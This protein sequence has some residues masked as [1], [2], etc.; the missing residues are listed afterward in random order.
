MKQKIFRIFFFIFIVSIYSSCSKSDDDTVIVESST[1]TININGNTG[2]VKENGISGNENCNDI[3]LE[4]SANSTSQMKGYRLLFHLSKTGELNNI[5]YREYNNSNILLFLTPNFNPTSE[6]NISNYSY[7]PINELLE[8]DFI[9]NVFLEENI[10]VK[11]NISGKVK[12][13]KFKT[14]P[15]QIGIRNLHFNSNNFKLHSFATIITNF[16][17]NTNQIHRFYSNNGYKVY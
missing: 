4:L 2:I 15:C 5:S 11:R 6:W 10:S 3:F 9:G 14:N 12:V 1:A 8:F 17:F 16:N 13:K 7:D